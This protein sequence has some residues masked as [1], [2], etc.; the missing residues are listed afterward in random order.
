MVCVKERS[1]L[2]RELKKIYAEPE[3][4]IGS[5][6][7]DML[8]HECFF[9]MNAFARMH[10][11]NGHKILG[12]LTRVKYSRVYD[13]QTGILSRNECMFLCRVSDVRDIQV[14][15]VLRING[16]AYY[17]SESEKVQGVYWRVNLRVNE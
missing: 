1:S 5:I 11:V 16:R 9:D 6:H 14:N 17:V 13:S 3:S 2:G 4:L 12:I 8:S 7:D 10:D 15:Q